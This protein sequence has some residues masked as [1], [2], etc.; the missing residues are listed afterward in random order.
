MES[1]RAQGRGAKPSGGLSALCGLRASNAGGT[2]AFKTRHGCQVKEPMLEFQGFLSESSYF[3]A[4]KHCLL[5]TNTLSSDTLTKYLRDVHKGSLHL[6]PCGHRGQGGGTAALPPTAGSLPS[7]YR[8]QG[9]V[10]VEARSAS[11]CELLCLLSSSQQP[12]EISYLLV[13]LCKIIVFT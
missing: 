11:S 1:R 12:P 9:L 7:C 8:N 13:I 10:S 4:V 6:L 3:Q 2:D 5:K